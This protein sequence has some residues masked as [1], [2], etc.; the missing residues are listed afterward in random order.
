MSHKILQKLTVFWGEQFFFIHVL[1]VNILLQCN[2][3]I[4]L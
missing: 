1:E 2:G 3:F 4:F